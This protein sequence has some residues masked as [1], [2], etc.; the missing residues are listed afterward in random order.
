[1]FESHWKTK[2]F[3]ISFPSS[4]LMKEFQFPASTLFID[5]GSGWEEAT[6]VS[7]GFTD[8][9]PHSSLHKRS[10]EKKIIAGLTSYVNE[11]W[12]VPWPHI[13]LSPEKLVSSP[14]G[15]DKA[16][17]LDQ[18]VDF[19]L[20]TWVGAE[21]NQAFR[22]AGPSEW[23]QVL[24]CQHMAKSKVA[25]VL[26]KATCAAKRPLGNLHSFTHFSKGAN[27]CSASQGAMRSRNRCTKHEQVQQKHHHY[28]YCY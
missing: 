28:Y 8:L 7:C 22:A 11:L 5:S 26:A 13:R 23:H 27:Q 18:E 17:S 19:N 3:M 6:R 9:C 2:H 15:E 25:L 12:M 1:M 4:W 16:L 24:M 20:R 10:P 14:A 21:M